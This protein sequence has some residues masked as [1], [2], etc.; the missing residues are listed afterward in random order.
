MERVLIIDDEEHIRDLLGEMLGM[1]GYRCTQ[2][3]NALEAREVLKT[4]SFELVLCDNEQ[5][6][7]IL[8]HEIGKHGLVWTEE[9][10][11]YLFNIHDF[12]FIPEFEVFPVMDLEVGHELM[13]LVVDAQDPV[14]DF[15]Q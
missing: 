4:Q 7:F 11:L 9:F 5:K 10:M 6:N 8:S 1:S 14:V 2:A 15:S 13:L 12:R 3:A